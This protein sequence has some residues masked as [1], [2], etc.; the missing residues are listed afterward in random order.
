MITW[1][2]NSGEPHTMNVVWTTKI[3]DS[4]QSSFT[5]YPD[6]MLIYLLKISVTTN[7]K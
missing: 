5:I 2:E 3:H 6:T 4:Y 1:R 7:L